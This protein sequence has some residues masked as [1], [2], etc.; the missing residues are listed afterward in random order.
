MSGSERKL[1]VYGA[2]GHGRVVAETATRAGFTVLGFVD[3]DEGKSGESLGGL[4]V[5]CWTI[6]ELARRV[7]EEDA[8]V[9]VGI[10]DN[11]IRKLI[12]ER[13]VHRGIRLATVVAPSAV[14]FDSVKVGAGSFVAAGSVIT[15]DTK[16][17]RNVIVNTAASIDHDSVI[18]DHAHI[19]PGAHMGGTVVVGEGTHVGI[20]TAVRNNL[21]IG[22]WSL[23]GAGAAV[24][25]DIES[26]VVAYGVPARPV[27]P[28]RTREPGYSVAVHANRSSPSVF[29]LQPGESCCALLTANDPTWSEL[30]TRGHGDPYQLP[31]Y[32]AVEARRIGGEP[33]ALAVVEGDNFLLMPMVVRRVPADLTEGRPILD[34]VSPYGTPGFLVGCAPSARTEWTMNAMSAGLRHLA[35]AGVC[36]V[37]ARLHPLMQESVDVLRTLGEIVDQGSTVW[38]DLTWDDTS[39]A[40][41]LRENHRRVLKRLERLG[42]R[43]SVCSGVEKLAEFREMYR[44]TMEDVSAADWYFFSEEY[45][46]DLFRS[47]GPAA[48]LIVVELDGRVVSGAIFL[49][50]N[51]I[52]EYYLGATLRA[53]RALA[54][55]RLVFDFARRYFKQAGARVLHL[56]GG[57]AGAPDSL[58]NFKA[59]FSPLRGRFAT[60]R[61]VTDR[62]R[63]DEVCE[64]WGERAGVGAVDLRGYFPP[65][66]Q[67]VRGAAETAGE[68][69][70]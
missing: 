52:V 68:A 23:L 21:A 7:R 56:G 66:R 32:A 5:R 29:P 24:V 43:A 54:P 51:G 17:G 6:D 62:P 48:R 44:E 33:R 19:S 61:V 70:R 57:L 10:G 38:M 58:F 26:G 41:H 53:A 36:S 14:V 65:Y 18:G 9:I 27:R 2:S 50:S 49:H 59:G 8:A 45:F 34:A 22:S 46:L 15:T 39:Y 20:G 25:A 42:A 16:I 11:W 37:F 60:W 55:S 64:V 28:T 47:L 3:D 67:Q 40:G 30:H 63:F 1:Y 31:E 4:P 69:N 12:F 35:K 13:I